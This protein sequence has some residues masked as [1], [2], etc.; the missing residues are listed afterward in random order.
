M[1]TNKKQ[2]VEE[3]KLILQKMQ[4]RWTEMEEVLR[5]LNMVKMY[6]TKNNLDKLEALIESWRQAGQEAVKALAKSCEYCEQK[7]TSCKTI[8][9]QMQIDYSLM[10]YDPEEDCF[11]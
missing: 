11:Y 4:T 5:K 2:F 1:A 7:S 10:K 3:M 6:R 9:D 8:L